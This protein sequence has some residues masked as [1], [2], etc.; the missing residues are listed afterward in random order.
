MFPNKKDFHSQS[1][2]KSP[3]GK[4]LLNQIFKEGN[5]NSNST[6]IING[7]N[8]T[9]SS[10]KYNNLT[11][12]DL[13]SDRIKNTKNYY[14]NYKNKESNGEFFKKTICNHCKLNE[15]KCNYLNHFNETDYSK[16]KHH[17][18]QPNVNIDLKKILFE[19][20]RS[21]PDLIQSSSLNSALITGT[22][23]F[24]N[25]QSQIAPISLVNT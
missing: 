6:N 10:H 22:Q 25:N 13:E 2:P 1:E 5:N 8:N 18:Q 17:N 23:S 15:C 24:S 4:D 12:S 11:V 7:N 21:S 19:S 16:P 9:N 20:I 3:K 14:S